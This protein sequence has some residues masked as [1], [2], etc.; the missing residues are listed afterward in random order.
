MATVAIVVG[1]PKSEV[2][3]KCSQKITLDE[4]EES[5]KFF[6]ESMLGLRLCVKCIRQSHAKEELRLLKS[7]G[8]NIFNG[9]IKKTA[10]HVKPMPVHFSFENFV[11]PDWFIAQIKDDLP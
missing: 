3:M 4:E 6:I 8:Y 7:M 10:L 9:R 1:N 11:V 2:C 5:A